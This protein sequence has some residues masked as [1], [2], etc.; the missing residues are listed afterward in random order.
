MLSSKL[1]EKLEKKHRRWSIFAIKKQM[2]PKWEIIVLKR[3]GG[4]GV[5]IIGW[6]MNQVKPAFKRV[7][8]S[9]YFFKIRILNGQRP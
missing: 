8:L 3:N 1:R 6:D 4:G 7:D 2:F 5:G 9:A